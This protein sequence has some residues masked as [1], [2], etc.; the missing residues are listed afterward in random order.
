MSCGG[1]RRAELV[2]L[3]LLLLA[4]GCAAPP[5]GDALPPAS[6]TVDRPTA[7]T[8]VA[9]DVSLP[10]AQ[11]L[12]LDLPGADAVLELA[13]CTLRVSV[14]AGTLHFEQDSAELPAD[15]PGR[16]LLNAILD[17]FAGATTVQVVGHASTEGSAARNDELSRERAVAVANAGRARLPQVEFVPEGVGSTSTTVV[18]DGTEATRSENRRVVLSGTVR[19]AECSP[20]PAA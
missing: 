20:S 16:V 8:T 14:E 19:A 13:T 15:G 6:S 12:D 11:E 5:E 4:A 3:V 10:A 9:P 2:G 18:E 17:R 7:D 1:R